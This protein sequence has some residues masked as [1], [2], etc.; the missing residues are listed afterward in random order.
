MKQYK[1]GLYEKA[2]KNTFSWNEKLEFAKNSGYDYMEICIDASEEKINRIYMDKAEKKQIINAMLEVI[3]IGSVS[4]SALTKYAL[5]DLNDT[6]REKGI[7]IMVGSIKL[8]ADLG[9][10]TVMLPG[11]DIYFGDS[12]EQTKQYFLENIALAASIAAKEGVML[13]FETMENDFMNSTAKGMEYVKQINSPYLKMYPD[14]GNITNAAVLSNAD[15]CEDLKT[16]CGSLIALHLKE[17]KPGIFREV[18]FFT[19][20]VEFERIIAEA[21]NLGIR[22]Y[23]TELWYT[24]NNDWQEAIQH[25]NKSFRRILD[26]QENN[27]DEARYL[28]CQS[29]DYSR[30]YN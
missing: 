4:V 15:V 10:R 9:I 7:E 18:A 20:H 12:T 30:R 13:G 5:G 2:M 11:Y 27:N 22:R 14:S 26:R 25:A 17:S 6:I 19:G 16:A 1:I 24:G 8:A 3:P 28:L 29:S 23:V 21:W